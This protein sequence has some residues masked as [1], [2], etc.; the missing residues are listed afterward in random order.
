[1]LVPIDNIDQEF[2]GGTVGREPSRQ[3]SSKRQGSTHR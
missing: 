2:V 3:K 1:L